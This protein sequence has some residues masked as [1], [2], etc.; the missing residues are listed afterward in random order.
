M[1]LPPG[2][3]LA[4]VEA[5]PSTNADLVA[6]ALRGAPEGSALLADTQL[7]GRGRQGRAWHSPA[8]NLH[9]SVI[10]RPA[11][12]A[13]A[14]GQI[15]L[16]AAI[17]VADLLAGL[18][19]AARLKWPNDVLVDGAKIAGILV[20]SALDEAAVAWVVVGIGLNVLS[21]PADAGQPAT[22]L[23]A[24]AGRD[25]LPAVPAIAGALLGDLGRR[26]DAWRVAG[27]AGLLPAWRALGPDPGTPLRIA[28]GAQA[29]MGAFHDLDP[30]GALVLEVSPGRFR[31]ILAGDVRAS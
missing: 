2:W 28:D 20:E 1:S 25:R 5:T 13:A 26:Y 6:E 31:R 12:A 4:R 22:S 10:L 18:G 8:G 16:V 15:G 9:L 7:A 30:D 21:H 19:I 29:I 27:F 3:R 14:A 24:I 23:A 11:C 17:A